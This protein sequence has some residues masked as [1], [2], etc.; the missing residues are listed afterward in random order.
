VSTANQLR[1]LHDYASNHRVFSLD[2][3][4]QAADEMERLEADNAALRQEIAERD[5]RTGVLTTS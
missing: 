1:H 3:L 2:P 4:L 5:A